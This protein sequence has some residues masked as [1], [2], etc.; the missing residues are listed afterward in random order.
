MFRFSLRYIT[1]FGDLFK[2][3]RVERKSFGGGRNYSD[4]KRNYRTRNITEADIPKIAE[5]RKTLKL[6]DC[7]PSLYSF[8]ELDPEAI[9]V[10]E[11]RDGN[12]IGT[13]SMLNFAN[14]LY[15]SGL[16]Y[17]HQDYRK[18]NLA[19]E[20][21]RK[22]AVRHR[23]ENRLLT[24]FTF[25]GWAKNSEYIVGFQLDTGF[26]IK[27]FISTQNLDTNL[28]SHDLPEDVSIHR[29]DE[30]LLELVYDYD[31]QVAGY[32]RRAFLDLSFKEQNSKILIALRKGRCV[33]YGGI[34]LTCPGAK[35]IGP[36]YADD[37]KIAEALLKS[38]L[39]G[40]E[41]G[42]GVVIV[43]PTPNLEAQTLVSKLNM[44]FKDGFYQLIEKGFPQ[45][46]V[47]KAYALFDLNGTSI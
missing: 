5:I 32:E 44:P 1:P 22:E 46:D 28:L 21:I 12:I 3:I 18:S 38:L 36:L 14:G 39:K 47:R 16:T 37:S 6:H 35:R 23:L 41:E 8:Y 26:T 19:L 20:M 7:K 24:T 30:K 42:K 29:F 13:H 17:V 34:K 2:S 27:R 15:I 33:G 45:G 4:Q 31:L 11:D 10:A 9:I 40:F 25:E 43:I